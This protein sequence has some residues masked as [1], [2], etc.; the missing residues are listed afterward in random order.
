MYLYTNAYF[1]FRICFLFSMHLLSLIIVL[2]TFIFIYYVLLPPV[3]KK[4]DSTQLAAPYSCSSVR[5][6][7]HSRDRGSIAF[8]HNSRFYSLLIY[9]VSF[10]VLLLFWHHIHLISYYIFQVWL[11]FFCF[12]QPLRITS[13]L[14]SASY[15]V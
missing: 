6:S 14:S 2:S 10:E 1:S 5:A 13:Y 9:I 11:C 8:G 15:S 7:S 4:G 12:S 3:S